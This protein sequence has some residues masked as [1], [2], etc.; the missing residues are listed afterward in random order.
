[1]NLRIFNT[2][3]IRHCPKIKA[4]NFECILAVLLIM[5]NEFVLNMILNLYF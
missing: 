4:F 1:M 5:E 3:S 2:M